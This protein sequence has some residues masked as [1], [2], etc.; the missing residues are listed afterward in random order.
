MIGCADGL[1]RPRE[2]TAPTEVQDIILDGDYYERGIRARAN[3]HTAMSGVT[4]ILGDI[5]DR[6]DQ[7]LANLLSILES[8]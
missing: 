4:D 2:T 7:L 5:E 3:A 8:D 6:A 1:L